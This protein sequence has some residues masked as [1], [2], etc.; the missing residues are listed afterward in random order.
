[1]APQLLEEEAKLAQLE[2]DEAAFERHLRE[3]HR[4][5]NVTLCLRR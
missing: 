3:A 5:S 2:G 4:R 1:L